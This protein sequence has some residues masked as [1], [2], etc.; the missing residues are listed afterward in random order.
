M[1]KLSKPKKLHIIIVKTVQSIDSTVFTITKSNLNNFEIGL[2]FNGKKTQ[3]LEN[4]LVLRHLFYN[5][6]TTSA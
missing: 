5:M 6:N 4:K 3:N 1:K 2:H